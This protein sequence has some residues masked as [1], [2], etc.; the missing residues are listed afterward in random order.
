MDENPGEGSTTGRGPLGKKG[1][2]EECGAM[3]YASRLAGVRMA[4]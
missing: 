4:G 1:R 3:K 2:D